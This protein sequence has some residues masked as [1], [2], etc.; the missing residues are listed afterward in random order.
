MSLWTAIARSF[1][2]NPSSTVYMTDLSS[3]SQKCNR[4]AFLSNFAL[5]ISPRFDK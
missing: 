3:T 2:M 4:S 1:V 5:C